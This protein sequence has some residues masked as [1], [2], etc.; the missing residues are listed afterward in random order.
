MTLKSVQDKLTVEKAAND[1]KAASLSFCETYVS[2]PQDVSLM[3]ETSRNAM[4]LFQKLTLAVRNIQDDQG[5]SDLNN[6]VIG[7]R[8][9]GL[10]ETDAVEVLRQGELGRPETQDVRLRDI[11]NRFAHTKENRYSFRVSNGG[12]FLLIAHR[13]RTRANLCVTEFKVSDF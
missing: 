9:V 3:D 5:I 4:Q 6:P 13:D 10:T 11:L 8:V 12:H 1:L 2:S 7:K